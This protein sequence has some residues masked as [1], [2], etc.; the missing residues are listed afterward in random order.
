MPA[1]GASSTSNWWSVQ[2]C[3]PLQHTMVHAQCTMAQHAIAK[4][5]VVAK[6]KIA[7]KQRGY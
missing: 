6:Q 5:N 1:P 7:L 4:Q 2:A 3:T